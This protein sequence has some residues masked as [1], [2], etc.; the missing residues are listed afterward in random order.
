MKLWL[1]LVLLLLPAVAW[2]QQRTFLDY[3]K[4]LPTTGDAA[5]G[6]VVTCVTAACRDLL[7]VPLAGFVNR[8]AVSKTK[9]PPA[10]RNLRVAPE[11]R[12]ILDYFAK[13][14]EVTLSPADEA[15]ICMD[16]DCTQLGRIPVAALTMA[17]AEPAKLTPV[18]APRTTAGRSFLDYV[19]SR[20]VGPGSNTDHALVCTTPVCT[21]LAKLPLAELEPPG[22]LGG[23]LTRAQDVSA[24]WRMAGLQSIGGIPDRTTQCGATITPRGDN[25]DDGATIQT[26]VDN[27]PGGQVVQ[28]SCGTF[29]FTT[30][31]LVRIWK[32]VTV[33]GCGPGSNPATATIVRRWPGAIINSPNPGTNPPNPIFRLEP[34]NGGTTLAVSA[35]AADGKMGSDTVTVTNPAN[36]QVG[37]TVNMG[38]FSGAQW[39]PD[40]GLW[41]TGWVGSNEWDK[42]CPGNCKIWASP[43]YANT[44]MCHEPYSGHDDCL[45][46]IPNPWPTNQ[47]PWNQPCSGWPNYLLSC[48]QPGNEFKRIK[49]INGNQITFDDPLMVDY[50]VS[51]NATLWAFSVATQAGIEDLSV[52]H[53][54]NG[55]VVFFWCN[56][57]W[58]KR[59]DNSKW[60]GGGF[61]I[62]A[63]FRTQ[64]EQVYIHDCA[65]PVN[66]GGGYNVSQR[67]GSTETY[68]VDSISVRCNKTMVAQGSGSGSVFAYNYAD[69]SYIAAF[70]GWTEIGI[71][72]SHFVGPRHV[73]FEGNASNNADSDF[74]HGNSTFM[75]HFRNRLTGFRRPF[76]GAFR[77][78][79]D[80][81]DD[82]A[83]TC[84]QGDPPVTGGCGPLRVAG[85]NTY[86]YW[87]SFVGNV[88][89]SPGT[90]AAR[91]WTYNCIASPAG[92]PPSHGNFPPGNCVYILGYNTTSPYGYDPWVESTATIDGNF[93]YLTDQT[94]WRGGTVHPLPDSFYLSAKP[95][96]FQGA[97]C[98]YP[99]PWVTPDKTPVVQESSC[100]GPD[101]P[102]LAR[103][104]AGTPFATP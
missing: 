5:G 88:L 20:P 69:M 96:F 57:C 86:S 89:G 73:L 39:M 72:A 67:W 28:L 83:G 95:A 60:L 12:P 101:L 26:A 77:P 94:H 40:R 16:T 10:P 13:L 93:D 98:T 55:S 80:L 32:N 1:A 18:P 103:Y 21:G 56:E 17:T 3:A 9:A 50:H 97:H 31:S 46:A 74:T 4:S 100:G 25:L 47:P 68:M 70:L 84:V 65:W 64:L 6:Q 52:E 59:V 75:A 15:L 2:G 90:T 76:Y 29:S 102:A 36:F 41:E 48:D 53:G 54:D 35:L 11:V 33:R 79:I 62:Y 34:H 24:N 82:E 66:G 71:N 63:S 91:G 78:S 14:P 81:Q 37:Q 30:F 7:R 42:G 58:A 23:I 19:Q 45:D 85:A 99:W 38:Q 61:L 51:R 22:P 49:A 43:D 8:T 27:C 87:F 92:I 44:W 104:E